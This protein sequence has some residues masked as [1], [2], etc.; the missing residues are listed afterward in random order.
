[1]SVA[2]VTRSHLAVSADIDEAIVDPATYADPRRYDALFTRL[3]REIRSTG[4]R[5]AV[6]GHSG[7]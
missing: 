6:T 2:V 5:P 3:R 7:A 4:R 1:M